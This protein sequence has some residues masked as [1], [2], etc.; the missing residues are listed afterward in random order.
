[1]ANEN[2]KL[3][4]LSTRRLAEVEG[5]CSYVIRSLEN[6][7]FGQL[8]PSS[9]QEAADSV[10]KSKE[11]HSM[12]EHNLEA[13]RSLHTLVGSLLDTPK[14]RP[15]VQTP[16]EEEEENRLEARMISDKPF[17]MRIVLG[18]TVRLCILQGECTEDGKLLWA[19]KDQGAKEWYGREI[20]SREP[21]DLLCC[22]DGEMFSTW[23]LI[24]E[25]P[26]TASV[27]EFHTN[28][29]ISSECHS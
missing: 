20:L 19:S 23:H 1:M 6:C 10:L 3:K 13:V 17:M 8:P 9:N 14:K 5:L 29:L 15:W 7:H 21:W 11:S 12:V 24:S 28:F 26:K 16:E 22:L 4:F 27:K 18:D 25:A 2:M